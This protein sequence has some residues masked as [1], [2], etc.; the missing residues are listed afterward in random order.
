MDWWGVRD[1]L[2]DCGRMP[3]LCLWK[4]GWQMASTRSESSCW[5]YIRCTKGRK[6]SCVR[7][8]VSGYWRLRCDC[9]TEGLWSVRVK[10]V[11][12]YLG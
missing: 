3:W 7:G 8:R 1:G 4:F 9:F 6:M 11:G 5:V 2:E 12:V 10:Q